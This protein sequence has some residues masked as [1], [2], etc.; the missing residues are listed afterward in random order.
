M[1]RV[2][3]ALH[4]GD[5]YELL[6]TVAKNKS[7]LMPRSIGGVKLTAIGEIARGGEVKVVDEH[8]KKKTLEAGG[9]DSFRGLH[10]IKF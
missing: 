6:F 5:D 8:G 7:R 3:L 4:G 9:W 2:K 10:S 1:N